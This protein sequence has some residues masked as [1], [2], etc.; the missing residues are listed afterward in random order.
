MEI[1]FFLISLFLILGLIIAYYLLKKISQKGIPGLGGDLPIKVL[2]TYRLGA[3]KSIC[4]VAIPGSIL[5]LGLTAQDIR[6]I[7]EI[8]DEERIKEIERIMGKFK[9]NQKGMPPEK[10]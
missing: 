4:L 1:K 10:P 7:T 3:N 2:A 9:E 5:V 8:K 6:L